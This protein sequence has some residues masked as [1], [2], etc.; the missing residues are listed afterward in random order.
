[1]WESIKKTFT[2]YIRFCGRADRR[3]FWIWTLVILAISFAFFCV[4]APIALLFEHAQNPVLSDIFTLTISLFGLFWSVM[5]FPTLTVTVRRLRDAGITPWLLLIPAALGV[6][7]ILVLFDQA[8]YNMDPSTPPYYS[9][10]FALI[11]TCITALV[12]VT[13]L[14][15]FCLP[16]QKKPLK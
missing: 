15:L 14:I 7:T 12:G 2:S 6:F 8:L 11:L 4:L 16:S 10:G 5:F 1:M 3:E 13:F 9:G